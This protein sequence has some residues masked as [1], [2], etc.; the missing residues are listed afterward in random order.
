MPTVFSLNLWFSD[1]LR[2]ERAKILT[3]YLLSKNFDIIFLQEA[4]IPVISYIYKRIEKEYPHIHISLEDD[5]EYGTVIISK[6]E[7]KNR[8]N[9]KFKYSK[10]NRGLLI[11][12]IDGIIYATTHLESEFKKDNNVKIQQFNDSIELL[13]EYDKVIF[14]GDTNL[15][16]KDDKSINCKDFIDCYNND[17]ND[18]YTYDGKENPLINNKIRS[19]IDRFYIKNINLNSYKLE[20]EFIMS[21]HFGIIINYM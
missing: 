1:N 5:N 12:E 11:G 9:L 3:E 15:T 10:M 4:I 13:S 18:K 8:Q 2:Y 19:R 20:K 21:D 16:V 14:G 6:K 7:I 17:R